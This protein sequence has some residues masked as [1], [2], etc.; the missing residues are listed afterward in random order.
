M[1]AP[2]I[3]RTLSRRVCPAGPGRQ[4]VVELAMLD[5]E[6]VVS[7][8]TWFAGRPSRRGVVVPVA[9]APLVLDALAEAVRRAGQ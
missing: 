8:R 3:W 4:I 9:L 5:G 7:V 2:R 6:S 1:S